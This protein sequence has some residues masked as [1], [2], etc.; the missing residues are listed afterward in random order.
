VRLRTRDRDEAARRGD[1]LAQALFY[2]ALVIMAAYNALLAALTRSRTYAYYVGYLLAY[3]VASLS[4]NGLLVFLEPGNLELV[5]FA[6]PW[7]IAATGLFSLRFARSLLTLPANGGWA[8]GLGALSVGY[9]VA[10]AAASLVGYPLALR[11]TLVLMAPWATLLIGSGVS[12][13]R[14]GSRVARTFLLAWGVFIAGVI[15]NALRV[16]GR[17][18]TNALTTN[19]HQLGSAVEF[20]LLS[21]ALAARIKELQAEATANAELAASNAELAREATAK[22]LEEQERANAELKRL[23]KLKDEFLANTSHE[24]RTPLNGVIG[25]TEAVLKTESS[26]TDA[27]KQ[28]LD[29]V[30]RSGRRLSSLV[31]DLLDFSKLQR[32]EFDVQAARFALAPVVREVLGTLSPSAEQKGLRLRAQVPEDLE[33][34]ADAGRVKQILTNLV[35]N[36]IKFTER[37]HVRVTAHVEDDR[38]VIAVEDT[39]L[40]IAKEHEERIFGPFVQLDA[41]PTREQGGTGLGLALTRKLVELHGGE[42]RVR[43]TLGVGSVF[44]FD[45]PRL[46]AAPHVD[47]APDRSAALAVP[48]A[49]ATGEAHRGPLDRNV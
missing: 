49:D 18:P 42:L 1:I 22:V 7:S 8:H 38:V 24:L 37:G 39:G 23:D 34:V 2:G 35:G 12:A 19:L 36:A 43:S 28:R 46:E 25:L 4:L 32:G 6:T 14:R 44:T 21:L 15:V 40:G 9:P 26:L 10:V 29:L 33:V 41:G 31:N 16:S 17:V 30:L 3:G 11:L 13:A 27:A 5:N 47:A 45:L 20:L 48:P